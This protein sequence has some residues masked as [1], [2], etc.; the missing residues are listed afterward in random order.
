MRAYIGV[1]LLVYGMLLSLSAAAADLCAYS[2]SARGGPQATREAHLSLDETISNRN[3]Q[4][5]LRKLD[6][7]NLQ[8]RSEPEAGKDLIVGAPDNKS[9]SRV[10]RIDGVKRVAVSVRGSSSFL[11]WKRGRRIGRRLIDGEWSQF[12]NQVWAQMEDPVSGLPPRDLEALRRMAQEKGFWIVVAD[13]RPDSDALKKLEE[14]YGARLIF[15]EDLPVDSKLVRVPGVVLHLS[16]GSQELKIRG[17]VNV[18]M[19]LGRFY[20]KLNKVSE[21]FWMTSVDKSLMAPSLTARQLY[22][23]SDSEKIER[24]RDRALASV[25]DFINRRTDNQDEL[26]AAVSEFLAQVFRAGKSRF[27]KG[28]FLKWA[29]DFATLESDG[30]IT[31]KTP[32]DKLAK[33]F[34]DYLVTAR[35][36][37]AGLRANGQ[38]MMEWMYESDSSKVMITYS[39]LARP[40]DVLIQKKLDIAKLPS[41]ELMEFRVDVLFGH[42]LNSSFRYGYAY[43]PEETE[44]AKLFVQSFLDRLPERQKYLSAGFDV[45]IMGNG[46]FKIIESNPGTAS[47]FLDPATYPVSASL[48]L[49]VFLGYPTP[50]I[51]FMKEFYSWPVAHQAARLVRAPREPR[52]VTSLDR[53]SRDE[54]LTWYRDRLGRGV[55]A[56][57]QARAKLSTFQELLKQA[58][59][60]LDPASR[61]GYE[62]LKD[63]F[64]SRFP[65]SG[66]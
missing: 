58:G 48:A 11:V 46:Q 35:E 6:S 59:L 7:L 55:N 47:S 40:D 12:D 56:P 57:A 54:I 22:D 32:V 29:Y 16:P 15:S 18:A 38:D 8:V 60:W 52:A 10:S 34:V 21:Y 17:D 65:R 45:A 26:R 53:I 51:Q 49:S 20:A 44:K 62:G 43:L 36:T 19:G 24:L 1:L 33:A 2:L 37:V 13:H 5:L 64:R 61:A 42:A 23:A 3:L 27:R 41:G 4:A 66:F 63:Y 30:I 39:L 25:R 28:M 14:V 9:W 31:E 50:V